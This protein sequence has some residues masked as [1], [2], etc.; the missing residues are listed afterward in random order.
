MRLT[1]YLLTVVLAAAT[2][3]AQLNITTT[4][5]KETGNNT[6]AANSFA[7]Q[8]NGNY[9]A[10]NVSKEN[11]HKLLYP[12]HSTKVYVNFLP[13]FGTKSHVNVGYDSADPNQVRRQVDDIVSRGFDGIILDWFGIPV[14]TDTAKVNTSSLEVLKSSARYSNLKVG[15]MM[16][17]GSLKRCVNT[18]GCD[19][20]GKLIQDLT[21]AWNNFMQHPNYMRINGRPV[22][23]SFDLELKPIDWNRLVRSIP[24]NPIFIF[25]NV[26]G[27]TRA[28]TGGS[29]SWV[30]HASDPNSLS[31]SYLDWFYSSGALKYP[32]KYGMGSVYKGFNDT[33]ALW[34]L[35]RIQNQHCGQLWL[36]TWASANKHFNTS[37]QLDAMQVVTW[38][39]YEEGTEIESGINNCVSVGASV[40]GGT[41][42][43]GI[44]GGQEN[45][46]DHYE[47][48][49]SIDGQNLQKVTE[50]PA[51][52]RSVNI[53]S[54]S[55]ANGKY[56][57]YVKAVG[58]P[59]IT[60]KMSNAV[61]WYKTAGSAS[62]TPVTTSGVTIYSP[63]ST[64][65]GASVRI[66]AKAVASKPIHAMKLYLNGVEKKT[67]G[68]G[69]VD[70]YM[71]LSRGNYMLTVNAWDS[72]GTVYKASKTFTVQ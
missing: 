52:T 49:I 18:S 4:L 45:T 50:V 39:D 21:Y 55:F 53:G 23:V 70:T 24:G 61:T 41:L 54:Y 27:F 6:S 31:T 12:G 8:P 37:N 67:I 63:S 66:T 51:G 59:S 16:D 44:S 33:I 28:Y 26:S 13:W 42:N 58:K 5:S 40:S 30:G 56:I 20:T 19:V 36:R 64:T 2:A 29:Y 57:L 15:L 47:V 34:S 11:V 60:N 46:I 68:G 22:V 62:T 9:K 1:S 10:G 69:Y 65:T 3:S 25:R 32:S 71:T 35:N 48:F 43:W 72:A 7:G 38:N 14:T 17:Q